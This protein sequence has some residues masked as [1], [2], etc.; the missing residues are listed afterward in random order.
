M[1]LDEGW[2]IKSRIDLT[3]MLGVKLKT[4]SKLDL[5]KSEEEEEIGY[6][7]PM[8]MKWRRKGQDEE[9]WTFSNLKIWSK[10]LPSIR[11]EDYTTFACLS[12]CIHF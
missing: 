8:Y 4:V 9:V 5:N 12:V 6:M 10:G 11:N 3:A 2:E 1:V 7:H